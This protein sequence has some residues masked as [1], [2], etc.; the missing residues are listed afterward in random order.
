MTK[1]SVSDAPPDP[2]WRKASCWP[3]GATTYLVWETGGDDE[4][5]A[6]EIR[7]AIATAL[8]TMGHVVF[9][10][11]PGCEPSNQWQSVDGGWVGVSKGRFGWLSRK[12][13]FRFVASRDLHV[14]KTLFDQVGFDWNLRGQAAFV[15]DDDGTGRPP[16]DPPND[17][18]A[19]LTTDPPRHAPRD[20]IAILRPGT[21]GDFAEV[22]VASQHILA[23]F[24]R[25]LM[26]A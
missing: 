13:E 21:D 19:S 26:R 24:E 25:R 4:T 8:C 5:V 3:N 18:A 23:E 15:L 2:T 9:L 16:A 10:G 14:V 22:H 17:F 12:P 6:P 1:V 7:L 20:C 11:G